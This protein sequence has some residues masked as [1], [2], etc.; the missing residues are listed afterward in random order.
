MGTPQFA[1]PVL[2][3]LIKT[4]EVCQVLTQPDRPSGRGQRLTSSP[5]KQA[6]LAAGLPV[7]QPETLKKKSIRLQLQDLN[8]DA[9]VVAAYGLMLTQ[10]I[11]DT[12]PLGCIN[13]HGSLL[14][15]YRGAAPMQRAM[16]NGDACTGI[17]IMYMNKGMDTG[18]MLLQRETSIHPDE[19]F[20]ALHDRM[21]DLGAACLLEALAQI[22]DGVAVRT[23]QDDAL[24]TYA[25]PITKADG[26]IDW[27]L[28]SHRIKNLIRALDPWMGAYTLLDGRPFKIWQCE[29][30]DEGT[31]GTA[32][33]QKPPGTVLGT[34]NLRGIRIQTGD[35][36]LWLTQV[37]A[38]GKKR[39]NAADFLR[40]YGKLTA[41]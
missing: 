16:M 32:A 27:R 9:F 28:P 1:V 3:A 40:G 18:D 10:P 13:V 35:G 17:T 29:I 7:W 19:S 6:A 26:L 14:P 2:D 25:P 36:A 37:Q 31:D 39:M 20:A 8:A 23:P 4:H 5:V 30:A 24:A 41:L 11:L 21:A 12:P 22:Q 34:D 38:N 15:A 33:G